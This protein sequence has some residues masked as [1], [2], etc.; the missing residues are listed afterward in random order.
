MRSVD[1]IVI[2][3]A[4]TPNGKPFTSA[5]IDRWHVER[6]FQRSAEFRQRQN[7]QLAAIGYHFV[8]YLNG[9][10]AT[11]RHLDELGAHAAGHNEHSIGICLIGTDRYTPAQWGMLRANVWAMRKLYPAARVLG[12]RDL[13]NVKKT[14]PGFDVAAWL[15]GDGAPLAGHILTP[16]P[17]PAEEAA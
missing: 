3:C 10:C 14:C 7:S 1:L 5:D 6:K 13:P 12:H 15:A 4:A 17:P 8:I 11:G 9:A 16:E 2:H